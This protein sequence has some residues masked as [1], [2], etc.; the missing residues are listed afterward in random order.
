[1]L[2]CN[3]EILAASEP[4]QHYKIITSLEK[5]RLCMP[6]PFSFRKLLLYF[7][8]IPEMDASGKRL[9]YSLID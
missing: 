7:G 2:P 6:K 9:E 4:I 5:Y 1:M 8:M 3:V